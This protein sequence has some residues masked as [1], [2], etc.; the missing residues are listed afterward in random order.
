MTT[1]VTRSMPTP[2]DLAR[3]TP[4]PSLTPAR[5]PQPRPATAPEHTTS[6]ADL[7]GPG[8]LQ[9]D[10]V[11]RTVYQHGIRI[12][13]TTPHTRLIALTL[14]GNAHHRSGLVNRF[15]NPEQ[16]AAATGLDIAQVHVQLEILTQRGWL[17]T[18]APHSGP[19]QGQQVYQLC[20][21]QAVLLRIRRDRAT[22]HN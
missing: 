18:R 4:R 17:T 19:R 14:L 11:L 9:S 7:A 2:G 10:E 13:G 1:P 12:S 20:V 15:V 16:L 3:R 21:P 6:A 5:A 8:R 22:R